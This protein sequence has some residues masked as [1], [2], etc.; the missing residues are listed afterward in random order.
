MIGSGGGYSNSLT[1]LV[2]VQHLE[3]RVYLVYSDK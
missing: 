1:A 2:I 3:F